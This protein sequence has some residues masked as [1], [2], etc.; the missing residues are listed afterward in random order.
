MIIASWNILHDYSV[1]KHIPQIDRLPMII[2][3]IKKVKYKGDNFCI[4]LCEIHDKKNC[5]E[6]AKQTGLEVVGEPYEYR[7]DKIVY[8]AFLA[9]PKTAKKASVN[10]V[11]FDDS[12]EDALLHVKID[13]VNIIGLHMPYHVINEYKLRKEFLKTVFSNKPDV[14]MGDFNATPLFPMRKK[15]L[16]SGYKE[17]HAKSRPTFPSPSYRGKNIHWWLP[18][19][20]IDVMYYQPEKVV[21]VE[22]DF[23]LSIG[24]DH[25]LI[26]SRISY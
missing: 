18:D 21:I 10:R 24:S 6:I 20:S 1:P 23:T 13:D 11:V 26:W 7:E 8:M 12:K 17:V 2:D 3:E 4:F 25:P 9:D 14:F 15:I 22:S 16:R 19:I 5:S